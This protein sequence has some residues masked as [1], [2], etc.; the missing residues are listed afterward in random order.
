MWFLILYVRP[1]LLDSTIGVHFLLSALYCNVFFLSRISLRRQKIC[2]GP[3]DVKDT[4]Q[5][6]ADITPGVAPTTP[7]GRN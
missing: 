7:F 6:H 2:T 4:T 1:S 5:T 3:F